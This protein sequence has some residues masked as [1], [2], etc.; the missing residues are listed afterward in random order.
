M[1]LSLA[2]HQF[3]RCCSLANADSH[4]TSEVTTQSGST[5]RLRMFLIVNLYPASER[6]SRAAEVEMYSLV[7]IYGLEGS[8]KNPAEDPELSGLL[9]L[10][11]AASRK[12]AEIIAPS[13]R[14]P[15]CPEMWR[16]CVGIKQFFTQYQGSPLRSLSGIESCSRIGITENRTKASA[17]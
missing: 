6:I 14:C 10:V 11:L 4:R 7:E 2:R 5:S 3:F 16:R 17:H 8:P 9:G 13:I 15:A 1:T 12:D